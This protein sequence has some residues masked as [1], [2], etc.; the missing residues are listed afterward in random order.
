MGFPEYQNGR[1]VRGRVAF[2]QSNRS[3]AW[4]R[5]YPVLIKGDK[6]QVL[7][8]LSWGVE[9]E[10]I[11]FP[12]QTGPIRWPTLSLQDVFRWPS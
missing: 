8:W 3:N 11:K 2:T 12:P 1:L 10:A 4:D 5:M 7:D 9:S 6:E